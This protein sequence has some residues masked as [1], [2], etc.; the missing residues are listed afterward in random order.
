MIDRETWLKALTIGDQLNIK[1]GNQ[2]FVG[3]VEGF[4]SRWDNK[5]IHE[6]RVSYTD[7]DGQYSEQ[8]VPLISGMIDQVS[9]Q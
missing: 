1:V 8:T 3:K 2:T 6:I 7:E 4:D 9:I 5:N